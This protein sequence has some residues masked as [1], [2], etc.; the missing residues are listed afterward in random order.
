MAISNKIAS[1]AVQLQTNTV[2]L[3]G[4]TIDTA[5]PAGVLTTLTVTVA[6][7]GR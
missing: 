2:R 7:G 6:V 4:E 5:G 1:K 3:V